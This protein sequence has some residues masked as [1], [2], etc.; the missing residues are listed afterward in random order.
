VEDFF[1]KLIQRVMPKSDV[2]CRG[3]LTVTRKFFENFAG[4]NARFLFRSFNVSGDHDGQASSG[5]R[6]PYGNVAVIAPFNFPV[7]IL[8]Y[9]HLDLCLLVT[10]RC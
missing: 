2:Q 3:E 10:V 9:K 6:W 5:Y 8:H 4:D 7:E 1:I